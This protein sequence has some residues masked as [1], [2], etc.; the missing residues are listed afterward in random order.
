MAEFRIH[1]RHT[2]KCEITKDD[3]V[4]QC[5]A[6]HM[7]CLT[8]HLCVRVLS[9]TSSCWPRAGENGSDKRRDCDVAID[10]DAKGDARRPTAGLACLQPRSGR[11]FSVGR[12]I[13][14]KSQKI[15]INKNIRR[16]LELSMQIPSLTLRG[17]TAPPRAASLLPISARARRT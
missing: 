2:R 14:Q 10:D 9:C 8:P 16:C 12:F 13:G 1:Q 6:S 15:K 17:P 11:V 7:M 4:T 5:V 3:I